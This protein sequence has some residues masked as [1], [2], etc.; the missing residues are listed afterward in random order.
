MANA[1]TP[2][3]WTLTP[4][5]V[6]GAVQQLLLYTRKVLWYDVPPDRQVLL[7]IVRDP[8]RIQPEDFFFTTKLDDLADQL[9]S[10]DAGRWSIEDTFR[11]VKQFL[12]LEDP[13]TRKA[14]GPERA[15]AL[16]LW[17]YAA[18]WLS[19]IRHGT[20]R[21]WSTLPWYSQKRTP[22]FLDAVAALRKDLWRQ[23]IFAGSAQPPISPK[24]QDVL[25]EVLATAA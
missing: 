8:H 21:T 18:I 11:S 24:I 14:S 10:R 12:G 17:S 3:Q 16:A 25:L 1:L 9:V 19:Y 22:S 4:V 7:V 15:V 2:E 5:E 13:Q 23:R 6:R 20:E